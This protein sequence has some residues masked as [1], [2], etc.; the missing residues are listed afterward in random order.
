MCASASATASSPGSVSAR[1]A[2]WFAIV[3]VGT[4]TASSLAEQLGAALLERDHG[5][6]LA[7]LLVPDDRLGDRT[8]HRRPSAA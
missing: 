8:P 2:I 1:S 4:K 5:R 7:L 3:A 6:I